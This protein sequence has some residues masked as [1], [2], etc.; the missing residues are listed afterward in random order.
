MGRVVL[1]S[2]SDEEERK[3][4]RATA[5]PYSLLTDRRCFCSCDCVGIRS[6]HTGSAAKGK[7]PVKPHVKLGKPLTFLLSGAN[8]S[9]IM[10]ARAQE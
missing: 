6:V 8:D 9:K 7:D 4:A 2:K 10:E 5:F 3:A 1:A